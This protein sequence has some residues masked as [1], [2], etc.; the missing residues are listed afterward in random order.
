MVKYLRSL[1]FDLSA[2]EGPHDLDIYP[3]LQPNTD[4]GY[5]SV[6]AKL[7]DAAMKTVYNFRWKST[8]YVVQ[9]AINHR[10][11]GV[12]AIQRGRP[13]VDV[14]MSV[15]GEYWDMEEDAAG[16]IWGDELQFLL[17][18]EDGNVTASGTDRVGKFLQVMRD[19]QETVDR[20]F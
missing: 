3:R 1:E 2:S 11:D 14:G 19:V 9:I 13:T 6:A 8:P 16:N 12:D 5:K 10:W 20:V 4:R 18:E 17:A 7:K 15:F